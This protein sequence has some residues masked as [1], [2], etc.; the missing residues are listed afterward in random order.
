MQTPLGESW[1]RPDG[2]VWWSVG[3]TEGTVVAYESREEERTEGEE[4]GLDSGMTLV[5]NGLKKVN[6]GGGGLR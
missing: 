3:G 2:K 1:K 6:R 5:C 4:K